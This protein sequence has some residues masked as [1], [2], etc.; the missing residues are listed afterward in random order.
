[1]IAIENRKFEQIYSYKVGD[2]P[3]VC[4][5]MGL[6]KELLYNLGSELNRDTNK[7]GIVPCDKCI[8]IE[9]EISLIGFVK[10]NIKLFQ[11][12]LISVRGA[13]I[14]WLDLTKWFSVLIRNRFSK[15]CFLLLVNNFRK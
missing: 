1:M 7:L 2:N 8:S 6:G 12:D 10:V 9:L 5:G 13:K 15:V 14:C 3:A 11:L 4:L